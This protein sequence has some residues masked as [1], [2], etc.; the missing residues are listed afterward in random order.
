MYVSPSACVFVSDQPPPGSV[1]HC[2]ERVI[3]AAWVL[4][5]GTAPL[6]ERITSA[7]EALAPLKASDFPHD[8]SIQFVRI[9]EAATAEEPTAD[10][11]RIAATVEVMSADTARA[12]AHD[13]WNLAVEVLRRETLEEVEED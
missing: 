12:I 8:L 11:G 13:I 5:V 6:P 10:E 3:R 7:A 2:A 9:W 1:E 4:A